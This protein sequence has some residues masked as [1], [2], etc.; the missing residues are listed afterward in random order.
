MQFS[1]LGP[2]DVRAAGR[3]LNIGHAGQRSVLA[4]LLLELNRVVP[5]DRLI[6]RVWGDNPPNS[7]RN[8]L[9]GYVGRLRTTLADSGDSCVAITRH[10]GGYQLRADKGQVDLYRFRG[11]IAEAEQASDDDRRAELL[12]D[13][14]KIW[15]GAAL[16]GIDSPWLR[17]MRDMLELQKLTAV[18]EHNDVALRLGRHRALVGEL[19]ELAATHPGDER[20]AG[21]LMLALYRS[22]QQAEAL[23]CFGRTRRQLS[24]EFGADP[25]PALQAMHRRIL[26]GD[27]ALLVPEALGPQARP[28]GAPKLRAEGSA[29]APRELPSLVP[30]FTGRTAERGE[31]D[32]LTD[33]GAG[34]PIIC[35]I[36]GMPGVGKTALAVHW[37]QQV[38]SEFTSGQ[39]Y[40][41]LRGYD[42]ANPVTAADALAGLL[43]SLGLPGPSIPADPDERAA[44]YRSLTAGRRLLVLLDNA[45]AADQVRPLLPGWAGCVTLVTSRD[46]LA[47]LVA[48]NGAQRL[49]LE[50][51][52]LD[53]SVQLLQALIGDRASADLKATATLAERCSRLPLALRVAA[54]LAASRPETPLEKLAG[55]LASQQGRLNLLDAGG[56]RQTAVRGVF[57]WSYRHLPAA[58][59]RAF[60][61]LS[62]HPGADFD[63]YAAA[64]L[65]DGSLDSAERV[66]DQL[67]SAH[68]VYRVNADRFALHDLLRDYALGLADADDR[69]AGQ[70]RA[71]ADLFGYYLSGAAT[72][73]DTLSPGG[74]HHRP[75]VPDS[76]APSAPVT[77]P[78]AARHW[79]DVHR[80]VLV[81]VTMTAADQD[82]PD[83]ANALATT[84]FRDLERGG[85]HTELISMYGQVL[86]AARRSGD[87]AAQAA[88][89]NNVCV[90]YLRQG[91]YDLARQHLSQALELT[92]EIGDRTGQAWAVGNLGL[93]DFLEG[94][95]PAAAEC[96]L[97]AIELYLS[98]RDQSGLIRSLTNLGLVEQRQGRDVDAAGHLETAIVQARLTG[99]QRSE[100]IALTSLGLVRVDQGRHG[101]AAELL[102]QALSIFLAVGDPTGEA[103][104]RCAIG[105]LAS[106][107]G[108]FAEATRQHRRALELLRE[109][110][111]KS[112]EA[113]AL[114]GLGVA[115]LGMG[116]PGEAHVRH[117]AALELARAIGDQYE[118]A[119]ARAG[120]ARVLA[121]CHGDVDGTPGPT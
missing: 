95:Y 74:Q 98:T 1:L 12:R 59:A 60:R 41:N 101:Q 67:A 55:E 68:L 109:T 107:R 7:V 57:W 70:R 103:D 111:N 3:R 8:M 102:D 21:Q 23:R 81:A 104:A 82:W 79:L 100:A 50:P 45:A 28:P 47:G 16:A 89:L 75:R 84:L 34:H 27:Q 43:R 113:A 40:V 96:Q 9:Y 62:L 51:L 80:A 4:V 49:D 108:D 36:S 92:G 30:A 18:Q 35:V 37:A 115:H 83:R 119:Q 52:P 2:I 118:Q 71:L 66:L 31:L 15:Q 5:A 48:R 121:E 91:S 105:T 33:G 120:L 22:G 44:K 88:A 53:D 117:R 99:E 20:I 11:F 106:E 6:D 54:E 56:D 24:D 46:S 114:N 72:A 73:M 39:L 25:G 26:T 65:I 77:D 110:S 29:A 13:A 38:A 78:V 76:A 69:R 90:V 87:R 112:S 64:A 93:L 86:A 116:Q 94:S 17:A 32:R 85:H 14:I 42:A 61:L 63:A 10:G 58:A 97:R 19:T